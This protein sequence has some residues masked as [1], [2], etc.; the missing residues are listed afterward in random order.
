[1]V[2]SKYNGVSRRGGSGSGSDNGVFY[3]GD[4]NCGRDGGKD[5]NE[6]GNERDRDRMIMMI[7]I[8]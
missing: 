2:D 8:H 5:N 3:T 7:V 4:S 6:D 1:M